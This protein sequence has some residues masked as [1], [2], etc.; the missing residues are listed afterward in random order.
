MPDALSQKPANIPDGVGEDAPRPRS[1]ALQLVYDRPIPIL[2]AVL[3]VGFAGVGWYALR[4]ADGLIQSN[5]INQ[6]SRTAQM[7]ASFRTIDTS[8]VVSRL[9][10]HGVDIR[11]D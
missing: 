7:L 10:S 2:C 5:A 4:L 1:R 6:A 11:H 9:K 8:D 3:I